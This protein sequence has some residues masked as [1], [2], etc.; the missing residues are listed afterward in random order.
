MKPIFSNIA[1]DTEVPV[2][3]YFDGSSWKTSV[4]NK[5]VE[6]SSP[7][8]GKVLGKIQS[9]TEE[10]IN[11]AI[12]KAKVAQKKWQE[13]TLDT[14][15]KVLHL[16]ADWLRELKTTLTRQL[17]LEIGK[18]QAEAEDEVLR[19]ADFIDY[20]ANEARNFCG[21]QLV[22]DSFPGYPKGKTA[23][24]SL[25][26]VG[27]VLAISPF[28][29]PINLSASKLAPALV[30][31]NAVIFKPATSGAISALTLVEIFR[32]SGLPN[33]LLAALTGRGSEI[34]DY[35]T[36][37]P[38]INM[39]TFTGSSTVGKA[40]AKKAG[41]IPLTFE[42]GGNNP[43]LILDD[44][45]L[46]LASTEIVK[47]AFSYCG[48]RCTAVKYVLATEKT[49]AKLIPALIRQ[50]NQIIV[51]DPREKETKMGPVINTDSALNIESAILE[52]VKMKAKVIFGDNR[53]GL[54][55]QP[56]ILTG[57]NRSMRIIREEIFGPVLSLIKVENI[58]Q[59]VDIINQSNYGLQASIFTKDEGTALK[60]SEKIEVGTVQINSKP[61][62]GPDHFPFLGIKDSGVGVQGAKYALQSMVRLKPVV[63][64]KPE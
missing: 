6:I 54:Y 14:R 11:Q 62:R 15:I 20:F 43:V 56:T 40:T 24:V 48:Q 8:T 46:D 31:G 57:V 32:K 47:G 19:T 25:V 35:L 30:T 9:V 60:L 64:N 10:E 55:L 38:A 59:A 61:Q 4:S 49:F 33:D 13:T 58:N 51:G 5:T 36:T 34:G 26:P 27:L 63:I 29:Y 21:E 44:A 18:T 53:R 37:H 52:A 3:K 41:M 23:I 28:N 17:I 42:C 2:Y 16:A 45:D 7:V 12:G 1:S 39:I 22:S 50:T